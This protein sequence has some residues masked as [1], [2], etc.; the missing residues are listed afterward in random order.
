MKF[1]KY[2]LLAL[3][4]LIVIALVAGF[5]YLEPLVKGVVHKFGTQIVGT[6]VNLSGFS[7]NPL[8]GSV[9]VKGLTVA[10]PK[11]YTAEDL[12]S[13]GGIR[14]K[15]NPKSLLSDTI[16]VEDITVTKPEITYEMPD[17]TTSNV[18]QIQQNVAKNTAST[19]KAEP[20]QEE[21]AA[22]PA[23]ESK[24]SKNVIIKKVLVEGG[25]LSAITPLQNNNTVL[26]LEMPAIE[27]TG[28]GEGKAKM[29]ISESITEIFNKILF[30]ATSVV[31]KA[32]GSATDMA[33]KAASSALDNAQNA[34]DDAK[35][36]AKGLLDSVKF[37]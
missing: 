21:A 17:F 4:A 18:M 9:E 16:V 35:G 14:V 3:L 29:T 8:A 23:A 32:L 6:E 19:A 13:L 25:A 7:F 34:A 27:L 15:V 24:P 31:T 36:E 2:T 5:L 37:W 1:V 20:A 28:I 12:L 30:N 10:N 11:G 26:T 33:K 22:Q